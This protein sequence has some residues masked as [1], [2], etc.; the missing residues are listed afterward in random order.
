MRD[1]DPV[2]PFDQDGNPTVEKEAPFSAK[3]EVVLSGTDD[4]RL[5]DTDRRVLSKLSLKYANAYSGKCFPRVT[6]VAGELKVDPRCVRRSIRK[7]ADCGYLKIKPDDKSNVQKEYVFDWQ[8]WR[9]RVTA[10]FNRTPESGADTRV[11]R[12]Q[13]SGSADTGDRPIGHRSP[14]SADTGVRYKEEKSKK[15]IEIG[16]MKK[17]VAEPGDAPLPDE[18]LLKAALDA[19]TKIEGVQARVS[20]AT[21]IRPQRLRDWRLKRKDVQLEAKDLRTIAADPDVQRE[22]AKLAGHADPRID[23]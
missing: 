9:D 4:G 18:N 12:T 16:K 2:R 11:L 1:D 5:K 6:T 10:R 22:L 8:L 14:Q 13:E 23:Q 15:I 17:R 20:R 7:L 19:T 21:G 3:I